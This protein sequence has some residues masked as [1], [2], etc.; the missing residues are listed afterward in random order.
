MTTFPPEGGDAKANPKSPPSTPRRAGP[1]CPEDTNRDRGD[2]RP[3]SGF[4]S[5]F[6]VGPPRRVGEMEGS[7]R[8]L[9]FD[10]YPS[11]LSKKGFPKTPNEMRGLTTPRWGIEHFRGGI[12]TP[13]CDPS[14]CFAKQS[15]RVPPHSR[16]EDPWWA[17]PLKPIP[18]MV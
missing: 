15:C 9:V 4:W 18:P 2:A 13:P 8:H 5:P 12:P 16:R 17:W 7:A 10:N 1:W 11:R 14:R 6:P 3:S